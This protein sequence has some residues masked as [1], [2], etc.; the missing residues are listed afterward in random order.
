[1]SRTAPA[2]F[3][4]QDARSAQ[5]LCQG[6]A[7]GFAGDWPEGWGHRRSDGTARASYRM[8]SGRL[9]GAEAWWRRRSEPMPDVHALRSRRSGALGLEHGSNALQEGP[10]FAMLAPAC[11]E[12]PGGELTR[13]D[14]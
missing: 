8:A 5:G 7:S 11:H 4:S 14:K 9:C 1:M 12:P 2:R 3:D 13:S 6:Q 10:A